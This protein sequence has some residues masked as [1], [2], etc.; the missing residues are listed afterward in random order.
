MRP[1][2]RRSSTNGQRSVAEAAIYVLPPTVSRAALLEDGSDRRFRTLV[3][4]LLTISARMDI[5]REYLG[6]RL[7][8]TSPQYSLIVAVAHLQGATGI[9]V[10]ALAQLLD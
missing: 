4:D 7:G 5:V 1:G 9:S 6:R 3:S 8:I 2:R 10:G